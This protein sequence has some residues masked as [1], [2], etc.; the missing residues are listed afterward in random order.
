VAASAAAPES[1]DMAKQLLRRRLRALRDQVPPADAI[2]AAQAAA[3]HALSLPELAAARTV[4][5]YAGLGSELDPA[6]LAAA[7]AGRGVALAYPRVVAGDRRLA[8]HRIATDD[9]TG[10][11]PGSFGIREPDSTAPTVPLG[12]IDL[13]V[14]PGIG[15]DRRG[16]RLGWGRGHYDATL[17]LVPTAL[18][19]G[20][21]YG[22]QLV[23]EIPVDELDLPLDILITE[24]GI[25]RFARAR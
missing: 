24:D 5:L 4:A 8:F 22:C 25:H 9:A 17:A 10:L 19:V 18:R 20:Y 13:F 3:A 2:R 16:G 15:F 11:R 14:L 12:D 23:D 7:L 1:T 21:G 6:P